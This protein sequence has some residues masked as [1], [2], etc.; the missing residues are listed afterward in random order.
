[1]N[2]FGWTETLVGVS[3]RC[4]WLSVANCSSFGA[5][6]KSTLSLR[7]VDGIEFPMGSIGYVLDPFGDNYLDGHPYLRDRCV[8]DREPGVL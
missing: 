7:G 2:Q 3:R 5:Q 8:S 6:L 4:G 1:M